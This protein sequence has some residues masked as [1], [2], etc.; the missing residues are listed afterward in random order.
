MFSVVGGGEVDVGGVEE[1]GIG[2]AVTA[3]RMCSM[4]LESCFLGCFF[5]VMELSVS[6][7]ASAADSIFAAL[8]MW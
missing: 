1:C 5:C 2:F 3:K 8:K 7:R 6:K 4:A